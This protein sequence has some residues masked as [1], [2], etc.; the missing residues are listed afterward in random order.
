MAKIQVDL[1]SGI[2]IHDNV[3]MDESATIDIAAETLPGDLRDFILDRLRHE[4][5]KRP[6]HERSE[7][8]QR[9]TVHQVETAVRHAVRQAVEIIAAGGLRTIRATLDQV[10]V[11]E[12]IKGTV[13]LSKHDEH[14]HTL[15]DAVGS[16]VLI[17]VADPD[18]FTGEREAVDIKPDQT[19]MLDKAGVVH[20]TEDE[21]AEAPFA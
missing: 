14:R 5:N 18:D 1:T 4:Q 3:I 13:T 2:N 12:G 11:K 19:E 16:T 9:D 8:E 20:S 15:V 17:V 6:W 7:A 21:R 10:T